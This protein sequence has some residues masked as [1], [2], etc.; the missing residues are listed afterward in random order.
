MDCGGGF[1]ARYN[2]SGNLVW[3]KPVCGNAQPR[4]V[5]AD[6]SNGIYITGFF[7]GAVVFGADTLVTSISTEDIF[8]AKYD[9]SG[10]AIWAKQAGGSSK[11]DEGLGVA[12]DIYGNAYI[13]GYFMSTAISFGSANFTGNGSKN[14]FVAKYDKTNGAVLWAKSAGGTSYESG[15]SIASDNTGKVYVSGGFN[16]PSLVFGTNTIFLPSNVP[17]NNFNLCDAAFIV[18]YDW[19]GNTEC[20]TALNSGGGNGNA[21]AAD[22]SG[23]VYLTGDY[24]VSED[25]I[26]GNDTLRS[27]AAS[28]EEFFV[29]KLTC[30]NITEVSPVQPAQDGISVYPNPTTGRIHV[31]S[32]NDIQEIEITNL[33][34][35]SV[36]SARP[37]DKN[38]LL[39]LN[40]EGLYFL[41]ITSAHKRATTKLVV[42]K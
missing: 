14:I 16:S 10:N 23:N 19:A 2:L 4:A 42:S 27:G 34:G 28:G 37:N 36:Y 25:F 13:T 29:A 24:M 3:V 39:Q 33:L 12:T 17:C 8:V 1:L 9:T 5:T 6:A 15:Y 31:I 32:L 35:Q 22:V 21:V 38:I 7:K 11:H 18:S 41:T 40:Q 30:E 20:A 26:I